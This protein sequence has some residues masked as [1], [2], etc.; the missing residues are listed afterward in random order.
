[1]NRISIPALSKQVQTE[2]DA[3][4]FMEELIWDG[5][6]VCPHCAGVRKHYFL[7]PKAPEGRKARTGKVSERRVWKCADCRRQ[8]TVLV[9]TIFHGSKIP[10]KTWLFV[11]VEIC[12]S[13]DGVAAREIE[14]KYDLTPKTA[15]FMLHRLREAMTRGDGFTTLTAGTIVAD[16]VF[17]GGASRRAKLARG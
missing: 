6:P 4:L 9:G 14:R 2:A 11:L 15:W 17:I 3:Y 12:A 10:V 8:F 5:R 7:T 16:E 1:V 13:K